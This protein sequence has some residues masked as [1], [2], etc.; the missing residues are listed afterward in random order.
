MP[1]AADCYLRRARCARPLC[2]SSCNP[3]SALDAGDVKTA[4]P[5]PVPPDQKARRHECLCR[6]SALIADAPDLV[7]AVVGDQQ[8]AVGKLEHR[9]RPPPNFALFG[10]E[11]PAGEEMAWLFR[12]RLAGL[13][14]QEGNLLPHTL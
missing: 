2:G 1:P 5:T 8:A 14:R 4:P 3:A 6:S 9:H 10:R 11:H 13:K 12:R 7:A